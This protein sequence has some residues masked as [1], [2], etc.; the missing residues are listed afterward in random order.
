MTW[1]VL[2]NPE[3]GRRRTTPE[4]VVEVL[5]DAGIDHVLT[6][7]HTREEMRTAT[8]GAAARS[9]RLAVVGGDGTISLVVDTI[10]KLDPADRPILGVLPGGSGTDTIR[11]F[12]IP[13]T[14]E[15]AAR[16]FHGDSFYA[17]DVVRLHDGSHMIN[18][19]QTGLLAAA[20]DK[21]S[22]YARGIGSWR[23]PI[24]FGTTLPRFGPTEVTIETDRRT[25]STSALAVIVANGQFFGGG[26]NI[27][28]KSTPMD[29]VVDV[30]IFN[31]T[32]RRVP[33]LVPLIRGG[34][35]LRHPAVRRTR[36]SAFRITTPDPWPIEID[37]DPRGVTPFTGEVIPTAINL[38]I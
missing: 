29:G 32:R 14:L 21:A 10:M 1:H 17:L 19:G 15:G 36:T 38:K 16:H 3:A 30:Q 34:H 9:P 28:P 18:V 5:N 2:L 20:V 12:A 31:L 4:R 11:T 33:A 24:A 7:P 35:H 6:V 13:R 22:R 25:I 37:G 26:W 27:A 23:Y 8:L